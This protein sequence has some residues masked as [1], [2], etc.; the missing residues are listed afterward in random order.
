MTETQKFQAY[1]EQLKKPFVKRARL[2]FLNQDGSTAF[3]LDNNPKNRRS[4]AFIQD[5]VLTVNLQNGQRR[6]A[7]VLL[8]NLDSAYDFSLN[9]IWFGQRVALDEGLVLPNGDDYYLPQGVFYISQPQ[10]TLSPG[11]K[12]IAYNLVDKW[13]YLDGT[14]FGNL[15]STY[16]VPLNSHIYYAMGSILSRYRGN[17][18]YYIDPVMPVYTNYYNGKTQTLPNGSTVSVLNSPYTLRI[19][20]EGGTFADVMLGL[21]KMITAWIGYDQTGRLRVDPSQDDILDTNKPILW[22]FTPEEVQFLGATY[23]VKNTDVFNDIIVIGEMLDS[24]HQ[25]AGRAFNIDFKSDTNIFTSLGWRTKRIS[26]TGYFTDLQC[27]DRAVWELKRQTVLKKAVTISC[28]QMFHMVENNL[29]TLVRKDKPDS[30]VERH[31]I[32]G[33]SRPIGQAGE[34]QISAISTADFPVASVVAWP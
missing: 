22:Q 5:G 30:P 11:E 23:T 16:E 18:G 7:T 9:K 31:L 4:G 25:C 1:L 15:E 34:M 17:D 14:L 29:I 8:S 6:Q 12:T 3:A 26:G 20:P 27:Q 28:Q 10:E 24:N 19:D 33:F 32:Q 13:A 21:A 2:R